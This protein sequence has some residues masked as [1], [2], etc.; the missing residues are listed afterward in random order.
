MFTLML[1]QR[2]TSSTS[3][4]SF[5]VG[6]LGETIEAVGP[7]IAMYAETLY[8]VFVKMTKD[9]DDEVRSNSV[10]SLGV[11]AANCG[12]K[13]QGYPS[14]KYLGHYLSSDLRKGVF[15]VNHKMQTVKI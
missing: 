13:I 11:L 6:T 4:K 5:A 15:G 7:S 10:Y 14:F 1:F 2:Q 9:E 12:Q 8:P 3:E